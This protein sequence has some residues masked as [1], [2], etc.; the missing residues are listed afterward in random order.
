[1]Q[2]LE[3]HSEKTSQELSRN[4]FYNVYDIYALI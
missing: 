3:L 1:M 4:A 2:A